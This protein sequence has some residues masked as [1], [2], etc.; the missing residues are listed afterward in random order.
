[1]TK[2][3][4]KKLSDLKTSLTDKYGVDSV[5]FCSD[6]PVR[7]PISSGS[8]ALDF[9]CGVGGFPPDRCIE[10]GGG[11]GTGKSS[12]GL[13]AMMNFLDANPT[14]G[15]LILDTE[16]RLTASWVEQLI[17]P[18]R[19]G[20][21]ILAW[22]DHLEAATDIYMEAVGSGQ[23]CFAML[24]S[25]GGSPSMRVT[26]KSAEIGQIGGNA[27]AMTR[28]SQLA[29]IYS[30]KYEC[31]TLG[32]NQ[33][34]AD[35][36]GYNRYITPGG[37]AWRHA[38]VLRIQL[39]RG[40][41][42]IDEEVSG[43]KIQVGYTVVGKVV[44]NSLAPPGRTAWWWFL[45]VPTE[46]HGFGVDR[47][48]EIVRLAT[49][50]GV[51]ITSGGWY[52]HPLLPEDKTG[53]HKIQGLARLTEYIKAHPEIHDVLAAEVMSRLGEVAAEV[54][55]ISDPDDAI[56]EPEGSGLLLTGEDIE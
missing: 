20:R 31:L 15:A 13:L 19:M 37:H 50:T 55:P 24:D 1:M 40:K 7:S 21:V 14:R 48:D 52:T 33:I 28:F 22:P 3:H 36:S 38:C 39:K 42:K 17:G 54:A 25:I 12:L 9:A 47:M 32:I 43:E 35:I 27:L 26:G 41:G 6:I 4:S 56:V 5:M 46:K 11:E 10:I 16:H 18:E 53:A 44:K 45:S 29:C 8:I 2:T 34:R 49:L 30:Q 51:I 23:I